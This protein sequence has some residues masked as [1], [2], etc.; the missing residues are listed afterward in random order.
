MSKISFLLLGL[1]LIIGMAV[2]WMA[3][4]PS[5]IEPISETSEERAIEEEFIPSERAEIFSITSG[6]SFPVFAKQVVVDPFKVK[7]GEEQIFSIWTRDLKG[8]EKVTATISTDKEG[9][10]IELELVEGTREEGR[11]FGSWITKNISAQSTYSTMF[12]AINKEGKDTEIT[13][14]WQ[15]EK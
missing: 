10:L 8:I 5:E 11:W 1:I 6:K 14:F 9:E 7:E 3:T 4:Q 2:Y 13:L 12:Q 15:T